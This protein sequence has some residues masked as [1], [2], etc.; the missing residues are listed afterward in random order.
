[1]TG[2]IAVLRPREAA[3]FDP[4][5]LAALRADLGE[6]EAEALIERALVEVAFVL[7]AL[8]EARARADRADLGRSLRALR[9][10]GEHVGLLALAGAARAVEDCVAGGDP[11]A[12]AASWERMLRLIEA[13][14]GAG[15]GV[16]ER[17][18]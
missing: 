6:A 13:A 4:A 15:P 18:V 10:M 3:R 11:V 9:R 8:I 1:M 16:A 14:L 12:L 5:R 2:K 7:A 17:R